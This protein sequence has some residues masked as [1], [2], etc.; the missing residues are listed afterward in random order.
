MVLFC[1]PAILWFVRG[2]PAQF[3]DS[4]PGAVVD[5]VLPDERDLAQTNAEAPESAGPL[6][7]LAMIP[8]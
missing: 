1:G 5:T 7:C 8:A 6:N 2:G 3:R 4:A